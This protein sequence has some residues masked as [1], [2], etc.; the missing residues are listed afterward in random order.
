MD[1]FDRF[2][3][4]ASNGLYLL[5]AVVDFVEFLLHIC[6]VGLLLRLHLLLVL[7]TLRVH[8]LLEE[9]AVLVLACLQLL[10]EGCILKHLGTVFVSLFLQFDLLPIQK[11]LALVGVVGLRFALVLFQRV[12]LLFRS[13]FV[14]GNISLKFLNG[15]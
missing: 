4:L 5:V 6:L 9:F 8:L 13:Q 14:L 7:A 10:E 1:L 2:F 12:D 3:I 15:I 11:F